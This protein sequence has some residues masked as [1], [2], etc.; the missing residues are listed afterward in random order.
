MHRCRRGQR[1]QNKEH[2]AG[3]IGQ[4]RNNDEPD[5]VPAGGRFDGKGYAND[6]EQRRQDRLKQKKNLR[7]SR[8]DICAA[9]E[10]T[11]PTDGRR[12]MIQG[13]RL[14][15]KWLRKGSTPRP[16][17]AGEVACI[18]AVFGR[19]VEENLSVA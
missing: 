9:P 7:P 4:H 15:G 11:R 5:A 1:R 6:E 2:E 16:K 10:R 8:S 3:S 13:Y 17:S 12:G 18:A 14:A 19:H